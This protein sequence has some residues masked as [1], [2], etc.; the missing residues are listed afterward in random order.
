MQAVDVALERVASRMTPI[1]RSRAIDAGWPEDVASRISM[2][3]NANGIGVH[4]PKE[5][6]G[7]AAD[8]EYGSMTNAPQSVFSSLHSPQM[9][10]QVEEIANNSMD[11]LLDRM[12]GMFS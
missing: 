5:I 3:R 2:I 8:L 11:E 1:I 7:K 9:K 6:E 12:R 4:V 10:K